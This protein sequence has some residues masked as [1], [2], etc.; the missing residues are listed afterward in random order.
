V[1]F[2]DVISQQYPDGT[3]TVESLLDKFVKKP[4]EDGSDEQRLSSTDVI[5]RLGG[6]D[7]IRFA[8][9]ATAW[10]KANG[11][12]NYADDWCWRVAFREIPVVPQ[13]I[14]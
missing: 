13:L 6:P 3:I 11:F 2:K 4:Q 7:S 5:K 8:K 9:R 14:L 10:F 1:K 12:Y